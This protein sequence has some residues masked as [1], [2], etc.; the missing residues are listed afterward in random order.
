M[1]ILFF[2]PDYVV[3]NDGRLSWSGAAHY[4][5]HLPAKWI[6]AKGGLETCVTPVLM[7]HMGPSGQRLCGQNEL[8]APL[9]GFDVVVLHSWFSAAG[10]E[11]I[12]QA[13]AAGQKVIYDIDDWIWGAPSH[14]AAVVG[15]Q[16]REDKNIGAAKQNL[17]ACDAVTCSTPVL[18]HFIRNMRGAPPVFVIRNAMDFDSWTVEEPRDTDQPTL[19]WSGHPSWRADDMAVLRGFLKAFMAKHDLRFVHAGHRDDSE[20]LW[21]VAN[22]DPERCFVRPHM[23]FESYRKARALSSVDVQL[24]PLTNHPFSRAKSALKGLESAAMGIPFVSS[25]TEEYREVFPSEV[26]R[27]GWPGRLEWLLDPVNRKSLREI[28]RGEAE[29][30]SIE[31]RW[32]DWV[33]VLCRT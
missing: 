20:P 10:A 17:L 21:R 13:R 2:S 28:Q 27:D 26:R 25:M 6:A 5:C 15:F 11:R 3:T 22:L 32:A 19:G 24:V 8:G 12:A 4:R 16:D 18:A 7:T 23:A 30:Q 14:H 31:V 9:D 29:A 33:D 1:R